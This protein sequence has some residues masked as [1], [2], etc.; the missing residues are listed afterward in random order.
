VAALDVA[1]GRSFGYAPHTPIPTASVVK[2]DILE[3]LL[4]QGQDEG[5][6]LSAGD[7][8][9]ATRMIEQSDN[10]AATSLW[11]AVGGAPAVAATGRRLGLRD[12][13]LADHWGSSTTSAS[14]Q[15]ILL[16]AAHTSSLLDPASRAFVHDLMTHVEQDQHWGVSAAGDPGT[17]TA[18]KNGWVPF[19]SDG[20][21]WVVGS[22]GIVTVGGHPVLLAALTEHQPSQAAGVQLVEALARV[23]AGAVTLR[24][25]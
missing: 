25:P 5:R 19:D 14:D 2:L 16:A 20:G 17:T 10:D 24:R 22:V 3:T 1:T 21:R 6:P 11:E 18:L 15:L 13:D 8:E 9:L 7:R 23:A 12:T 4:L